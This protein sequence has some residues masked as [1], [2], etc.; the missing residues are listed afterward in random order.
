MLCLDIK[1]TNITVL[2]ILK[3]IHGFMYFQIKIFPIDPNSGPQTLLCVFKK[4][5]K[6]DTLLSWIPDTTYQ[7]VL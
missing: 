5:C 2:G 7:D 1:T 4:T 6:F 3:F